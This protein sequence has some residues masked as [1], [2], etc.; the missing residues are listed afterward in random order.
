MTKTTIVI[1][2]LAGVLLA[3]GCVSRCEYYCRLSQGVGQVLNK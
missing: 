3:S 2:M 1:T